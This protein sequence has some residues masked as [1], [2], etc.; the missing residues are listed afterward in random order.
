MEY[1]FTNVWGQSW[2]MYKRSWL[3]LTAGVVIN[4]VANIPTQI[5][6]LAQN[7]LLFG[8]QKIQTSRYGRQFLEGLDVLF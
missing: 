1:S 6:N 7:G 4:V 2:A 3:M 5:S 8:Q